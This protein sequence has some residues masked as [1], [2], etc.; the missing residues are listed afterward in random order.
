MTDIPR[1]ER[2]AVLSDI[3]GVL[4]VLEAVLAEPEVAAAERIVLTGDLAAG[5][6][7]VATLD[8]LVE[9]GDRA[10]W[11]NGNADRE[12][13]ELARDPSHTVADPLAPWAAAQLRPDQVELLA[14]LPTSVTAEIAGLGRTVFCHATPRDDEEVVVVDSRPDRWAEVFDGLADEVATVICGHTHMPFVRLVDGRWVVNPGSVGMPYAPP[15]AYWA[16][17]GPGIALRRTPFDAA[18]A[19]ASVVAAS[20]YPDVASW[21]EEY[22]GGQ[23]TDGEAL[24]TFGPLDGR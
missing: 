12:L 19:G 21:V 20:G 24:A 17:L 14:G 11:V 2:V 1:W 4:P 6:Q 13:V 23:V 7:P 8:R 18:A 3:H 5:P 16:L 15:G 9:L 10:V 22:L